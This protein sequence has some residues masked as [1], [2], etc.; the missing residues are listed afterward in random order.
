VF[1]DL[2]KPGFFKESIWLKVRNAWKILVKV[3]HII[4]K[5]KNSDAIYGIVT[6]LDLCGLKDGFW[7]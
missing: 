3:F 5:K 7:L 4:K 1:T 2:W 6:F